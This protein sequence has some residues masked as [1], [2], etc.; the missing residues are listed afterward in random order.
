MPAAL[1]PCCCDYILLELNGFAL[2]I[3]RWR[4][5]FESS[6]DVDKTGCGV[7]FCVFGQ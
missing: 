5:C 7:F 6:D 2:G 3:L 4:D 1:H